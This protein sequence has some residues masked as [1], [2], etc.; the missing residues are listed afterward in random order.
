[1]CLCLCLCTAVGANGKD[2]NLEQN[3]NIADDSTLLKE[4]NIADDDSVLKENTNDKHDHINVL[5]EINAAIQNFNQIRDGLTFPIPPKHVES[6]TV[7][8]KGDKTQSLPKYIRLPLVDG[9]KVGHEQEVEIVPGM[10]RTI[11]TLSLVPVIFEMDEFLDEDE[12]ELLVELSKRKR[13]K[14]LHDANLDSIIQD[15][16]DKTFSS[17]DLNGDEFVDTEEMALVIGRDIRFSVDDAD[18]MF[19]MLKMD[20]NED[21]RIDLDELTNIDLEDVT[22]YID[23]IKNQPGK[24]RNMTTTATW[25]WHDEDELLRFQDDYFYGYH[26]RI[27]SVTGLP[28]E[29]IAESEPL[30]VQN[31]QELQFANC[32]GHSDEHSDKPCCQYGQLTECRL[33]RYISMAVFLND[34]EE[35]GEMLFPMADHKFSNIMNSSGEWRGYFTYAKTTGSKIRFTADMQFIKSGE[36]QLIVGEGQDPGGKFEIKDGIITGNSVKFQKAYVSTP[37]TETSI[38]YSGKILSGSRILGNWWVPNKKR[39]YGEFFMWNR[40]YDIMM[41]TEASKCNH[42]DY[43]SKSGLTIKPK[44]GKA[45]FWYN[46]HLDAQLGMVGRKDNDALVGHCPVRKGEK[47]LATTWLNVIGDGED[48]LRAWRRGINWLQN[49]EKYSNIFNKIGS[50]ASRTNI[51]EYKMDFEQFKIEEVKL[52]NRTVREEV[53]RPRKSSSTAASAVES[54]LLIIDKE[55]L[56][57]IASVVHNKLRMQC[58]P[59][60]VKEGGKLVLK[61]GT[62]PN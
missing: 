3:S 55:G 30:Q 40:N 12:C 57:Q 29:I 48:E 47:W 56:E 60:Y 2:I 7:Q 5:E 31:F 13:M 23:R 39:F 17:W 19:F 61:D 51:E 26:S 52:E 6:P 10:I 34:V 16:P 54:L 53:S 20:K 15:A 18:I 9:V 43:C 58:V 49:K 4:N 35:G 22:R 38:I 8:L 46:H 1:M 28:E 21:G 50:D 42:E 32:R 33:C 14:T 36:N 37:V 41:K 11:K 59:F 27:A 25:V 24:E 62:R 44:Q 45:I